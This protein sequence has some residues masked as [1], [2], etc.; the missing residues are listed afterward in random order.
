MTSFLLRADGVLRGASWITRSSRPWTATRD[1]VLCV[2]LFGLTYGAAM[3]TFGG[4]TGDRPLQVLYS[5]C[6]VPL[7][8]LGTFLLSLPSFAV[9]NTLFGLRRDLGEAIRAVVA[10]QA[11]VATVLAS[12]APF[13]LLWYVS[14]V[15]Y[16][17]A[18]LF[19]AAMFTI[20]SLAGQ[21]LLRR[22]YQP[23]IARNRR[24]RVLLRTWIVVY[25][26]V[27]IQMGWMF[28]PFIGSPNTPVQFFR[29]ETWGN[30]YVIVARLLWQVIA[31]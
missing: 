15:S 27:G 30:A 5:A 21:R 25:A 13:T 24:H 11:G 29:E 31:L 2:C 1:L 17:V 22:Y 8:L 3:G 20:A 10:A 16:Q 6:K 26:F 12:L 4:L 14:A 28:R 7:L 9:I 18:I 23:L 19:N